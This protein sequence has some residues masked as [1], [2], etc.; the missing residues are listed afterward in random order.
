[1]T[2]NLHLT[3]HINISDILL[4]RRNAEIKRD[5]FFCV[6]F[7]FL[8]LAIISDILKIIRNRQKDNINTNK[9]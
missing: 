7:F 5:K 3:S 4:D 9:Q 2:N 1:M 8:N 6:F